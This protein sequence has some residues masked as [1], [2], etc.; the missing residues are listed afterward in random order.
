VN[1]YM[2]QALCR[3]GGNVRLKFQTIR[4]RQRIWDDLGLEAQAEYGR[5]LSY[6][7]KK[8]TWTN[9]CRVRLGRAPSICGSLGRDLRSVA[10]RC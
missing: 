2:P 9:G 3:C 4:H 8:Q 1:I 10:F 5:E 6:W 7:Q